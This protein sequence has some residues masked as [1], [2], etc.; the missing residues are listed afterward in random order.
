MM[1]GWSFR[2]PAGGNFAHVSLYNN[3]NAGDWLYVLD[4]NGSESGGAALIFEIAQGNQGFTIDTGSTAPLI[5]GAPLLAGQIG[6]FE[7]AACLGTHRGGTGNTT[8]NAAILNNRYPLGIIPP[9]WSFIVEAGAGGQT[10]V[11]GIWWYV[12]GAP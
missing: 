11:A 9:T 7:T 1:G 5:G 8:I 10:V 2:T 4:V 12:G 6:T 3:S